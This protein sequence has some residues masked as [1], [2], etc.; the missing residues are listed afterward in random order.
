VTTP[1]FLPKK[2][3]IISFTPGSLNWTDRTEDKNASVR[4]ILPE[5][6]NLKSVFPA[7]CTSKKHLN[8]PQPAAEPGVF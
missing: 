5:A 3:D 7:A 1:T 4:N 6:L 8:P 2:A